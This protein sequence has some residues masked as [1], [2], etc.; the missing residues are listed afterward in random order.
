[1]RYRLIPMAIF[2]FILGFHPHIPEADTSFRCGSNLISLGDTMHEVRGSCGEPFSTQ[3]VGEK[4]DYRIINEDRLRIESI[5]YVTEW[6]YES[7]GG[8]YVLTFEGSRLGKKEFIYQ[9]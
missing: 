6:I 3:V 8:I 4:K 2:L 5:T 1:M 7:A 9:R